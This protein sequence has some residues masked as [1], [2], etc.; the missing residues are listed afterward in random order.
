[1]DIK[2][3]TQFVIKELTLATEFGNYDISGA[4]SELVLYD[5]LYAPLSLI[6]I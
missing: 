4:F 5:S 6:H 1:M 3:S 2:Q